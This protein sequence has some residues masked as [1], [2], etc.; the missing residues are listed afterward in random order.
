MRIPKRW[1][2][3]PTGVQRIRLALCIT[4]RRSCVVRKKGPLGI[5]SHSISEGRIA[6]PLQVA[7]RGPV[8]LKQKIQWGLAIRND[9]ARFYN[10]CFHCGVRSIFTS[11]CVVLPYLPG[12]YRFRDEAC[13]HVRLLAFPLPFPLS[14]SPVSPPSWGLP[15]FRRV[16]L[17]ARNSG[18]WRSRA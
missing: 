13:R 11:P 17:F 8:L 16:L 3:T 4:S 1:S 15:A 14:R 6:F 2:P 10:R 18:G 5:R 12:A 9:F 7:Q